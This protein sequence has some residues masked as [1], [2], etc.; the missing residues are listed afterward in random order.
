MTF[1]TITRLCLS[2][3]LITFFLE[4]PRKHSITELSAGT[5]ERNEEKEEKRNSKCA[6]L[7]ERNLESI[8]LPAGQE[9]HTLRLQGAG[10][11]VHSEC[12]IQGK[13]CFPYYL[14]AGLEK[15]N[16]AGL[17]CRKP[18]SMLYSWIGNAGLNVF[19]V[20]FK[21]SLPLGLF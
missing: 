6:F 17:R 10:M 7:E 13:H 14:A 11:A 12:F 16:L 18:D 3:Q 19:E 21:P 8:F 15:L 20:K 5:H 9:D 2:T 4:K 1:V